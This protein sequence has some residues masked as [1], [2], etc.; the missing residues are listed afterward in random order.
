MRFHYSSAHR[1]HLRVVLRLRFLLIAAL[2]GL[3]G[4]NF[5]TAAPSDAPTGVTATPGDGL[6]LMSWDPL[7]DL[8]Y[9]I[10]FTAGGSVTNAVPGS[11]VIRDATNPQV[12]GRLTNGTQ[13]AFIMNATH[14]DSPAGPNSTVVVATPRLAGGTNP[15]STSTWVSGPA[16]APQN[17]KGI[18]FNGSRFVVVG[19]NATIFAGDFN[20]ANATPPGVTAW[21]PANAPLPVTANLTGVV[22]SGGYLAMGTDGS[23]LT[24]PDGLTWTQAAQI[25]GT[26]MNDIAVGTPGGST[27]FVA[28]GNGGA[29]FNST[30]PTVQWNAAQPTT[31]ASTSD[32]F[33]VS[34]LNGQFVA[35]GANGTLLTSFDGNT[36]TVQNSNTTSAL[37]GAAFGTVATGPTAGPLY[38][39]VGDAGTIATSPD[40]A[41]WTRITPLAQNLNGV[42]FGSRFVAVGQGGVV[43]YS[44]DGVNWKST[45]SGGSSDLARVLFPPGMYLAIGAAGANAVSR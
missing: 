36:W 9:W 33:S 42:V 1:S 20:Y 45:T 16:I 44:D 14:F 3:A 12:V 34:F 11:T 35:T 43:A 10:F 25:P 29:I 37:R 2:I 30:N 17:L 38:V 13:Y 40:G 5:R 28:V 8:T 19:D 15:D 4:C 21:M 32:L 41:G 18:A 27:T 7:P 39:V 22:V 26:G 31:P 6:I 23:T 24:S